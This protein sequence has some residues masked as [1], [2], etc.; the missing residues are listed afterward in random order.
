MIND[1][2]NIETENIQLVS[3]ISTINNTSAGTNPTIS[4]TIIFLNVMR[5]FSADTI[6]AASTTIVNINSSINTTSIADTISIINT[7]KS[8]IQNI[9]MIIVSLQS[10]I[11]SL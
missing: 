4:T 7:T 9:A 8:S 11:I 10:T 2:K 6:L 3:T 5:I 1:L